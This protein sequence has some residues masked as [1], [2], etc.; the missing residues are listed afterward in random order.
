MD[1]T[2]KDYLEQH[3]LKE[4][5][6]EYLINQEGEEEIFDIVR[7]AADEGVKVDF[8]KEGSALEN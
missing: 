7:K 8:W 5:L 3:L 2:Y 4:E 1:Q 6:E